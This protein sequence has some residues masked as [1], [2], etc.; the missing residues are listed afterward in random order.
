MNQPGKPIFKISYIPVFL[1]IV[2]LILPSLVF[3][4]SG[5]GLYYFDD[6]ETST[7][8]PDVKYKVI[9]VIDG[10][11]LVLSNNEH[12]RLIGI[13]TPESESYFYG[14]A[15][16]VLKLLVLNKNVRLEKDVDDR[17]TYGR[18][19]RYVYIGNFF[20]N[21]E[22]VKR[23]FANA[24]TFP[25]NVKYTDKFIEAEREART[26]DIGLWEKSNSSNIEININCDAEGDDRINLNGEY[27][28]FKN[29]NN[30]DINLG[31]WTVKDLSTNI[32]DFGKIIF[33]SGSNLILF[34]GKG[35]DSENKL[36]WNSIKPIWN[37]DHDTLYLRDAD[38][39]IV[40]LYNY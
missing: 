9:E 2:F 7:T 12:V 27:V 31:G 11:T 18:L 21:L 24:F 19:L 20:V 8:K 32:Y 40:Q 28:I 34:S 37:N 26:N 30:F 14:E 23:G 15:K 29:N 5:C 36:Y 39:L 16:E 1:L 38:G 25:P 6:E 22:M 33:K 13:N 3:S 17:D 10:D 4:L 35:S